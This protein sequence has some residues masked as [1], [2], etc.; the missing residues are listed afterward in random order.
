MF[1]LPIVS[2]R[3]RKTIEMGKQK[4]DLINK[5]PGIVAIKSGKKP[6]NPP[7]DG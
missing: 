1:T 4:P 7:A 5:T 6:Q 3:K 2:G